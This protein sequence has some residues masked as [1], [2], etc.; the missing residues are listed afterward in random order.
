MDIKLRFVNPSKDGNKSEVVIYQRNLLASMG[1]I[2]VAWKVI[3]YCGRDC[4][5]P[6]V[7]PMGYEVSVADENGNF[8][9]PYER[10]KRSTPQAGLCTH[11]RP[12][13]AASGFVQRL[14][15][16][17]SAQRPR[18]RRGQCLRAQG[19]PTG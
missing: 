15:R 2:A 7:H 17:E 11:R 19:W 14:E 18:Q 13:P 9:P 5:H 16:A 4:H 12:A 8:L 10:R 1:S 3:R 6:F